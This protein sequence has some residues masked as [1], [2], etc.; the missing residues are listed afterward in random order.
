MG[1]RSESGET[2]KYLLEKETKRLYKVIS[3]DTSR[4]K[5]RN[6]AIFMIAKY[7]ALRVSE[8]GLIEV[9]NFN[10]D[11]NTI[12]CKRLKGSRNNTLEIVDL[13]V[14]RSLKRYLRIRRKIDTDSPYLFISMQGKKISRQSLDVL[15][16]YYCEKAN[17]PEEKRHFHVLKHT[18]AIELAESGFD[19]KELQFWLGHK[20]VNNTMI[21]FTFTT[22]QQKMMYSK[23]KGK[24]GFNYDRF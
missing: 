22:S 19:L 5:V 9:D 23:L 8:V 20:N 13:N 10:P 12:Y 6:E 24:G 3:E 16:R 15:M 4:Y 17:I 7:C 1:Q 2:I 11:T 21:Y 18:R 14:L